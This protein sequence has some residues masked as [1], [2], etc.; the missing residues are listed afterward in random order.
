V[1]AQRHTSERRLTA[2]D[3]FCGAGG[4]SLGLRQ[5]GFEVLGAVEIS[6]LAARTYRLNHRTTTVWQQNIRSLGPQTV[7]T[8]LDLE[9]GDLDL[10]AACPP[11]QGFSSMRTL[12]RTTSVDDKR[13]SLVAQFG[14]YAEALRPK[15]LM[16]ENVPGLASDPRLERLLKRLRRLGYLI[17]K[18]VLDAADYGV[19]QRRRR[20]VMI[21]MLERSVE[22]APKVARTRTVRDAIGF[23]LPPLA[24]SDP[25][26]THGENRSPAVQ[27]R[28][29]AIPRDGGSL[30]DAGAKHTLEC[31]RKLK[32]FND[33]YGRMAWDSPA[34]TITGG[35]VNPSKG[36]FLHPVHNRAITLREAAL[37]QSFPKSYRFPRDAP[38]FP[39][40]DLI[41]NALP[42]R[43]VAAHARQLAKSLLAMRSPA[44]AE[45][46]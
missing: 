22:F 23:L 35:C 20:F 29:A 37:L 24:S 15:A 31:R 21:A 1:S 14:R 2:I 4:L 44:S 38:K 30:R 36:R 28:I 34:P 26:H 45:V 32:G 33:V 8:A 11:C 5:A 7:L 41:G 6:E 46:T 3:L 19:P 25:L 43:F 17:T 40:A 27:R 18:D 12:L 13:N 10:L 42:P 16:L 9:P 39:L